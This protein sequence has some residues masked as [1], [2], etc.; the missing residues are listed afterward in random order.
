MRAEFE[1]KVGVIVALFPCLNRLVSDWMTRN[2]LLGDG[3]RMAPGFAGE[4]S[5]QISQEDVGDMSIGVDPEHG[6]LSVMNKCRD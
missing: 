5:L 3:Q 1:K 6:R 4:S 2:R